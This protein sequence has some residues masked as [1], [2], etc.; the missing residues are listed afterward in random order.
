MRLGSLSSK[1]SESTRLGFDMRIRDFGPIKNASIS[2][3]PL[4]IFIGGN[5]LG[6]S[7]AAML[8]HSVVSTGRGLGRAAHLLDQSSRG[9]K[10]S[11][12]LLDDFE[13]V[14]DDLK[15]RGEVELPP[16]LVA[17]LSRL[18]IDEYRVRLQS[19]IVRNFGSALSDLT[20]LGT[21]HFSMSL[22]VGKNNIMSYK[23]GRLTLNSMP[24]FGIVL[25]LSKAPAMSDTFHFAWRDDTLHCTIEDEIARMSN[26]RHLFA[27]LYEDLRFA[28]LRQALAPLPRHSRY[29]PAARSGIL[30]AHRVIT[31]NIVRNAPYAGIEDIHVPRLSG[32]VSDFVSSIID[33]HPIRGTH[34]D[35]GT[36]IENDIF[37]GHI[38]MKYTD[39]GTIPEIIYKRSAMN[40]PIHRTS[41]TISE[42]APFTLHLKHRLEEHGVLIIEEPEAHLHPRNQSL[43][44]QHIV[45]LVRDGANIIITTH[46]SALFESV[47]QYLQA[48]RLRPEERENAFGRKDLYLREDEVAPH[49]F[50]MD[51]DGGSVVERIGMSKEDGITQEEFV[52]EDQLLN[53]TNLRIEEHSN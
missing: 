3:R 2:L 52:R 32:V 50:K 6:K 14:L 4:T 24:K 27:Y 19:E 11:K 9:M 53:E 49:L 36:Q 34:H 40:V 33:M 15:S 42:L 28:I 31:S 47:S 41:S 38:E 5:D 7:Y 25:K 29:F 43:L 35:I 23:N 17:Q 30:Q 18:C 22:K 21:D 12:S 39:P 51:G 37:G 8:A 48:S 1:P 13:K 10:N 20:R 44:A 45:K 46:S 16:L 26:A